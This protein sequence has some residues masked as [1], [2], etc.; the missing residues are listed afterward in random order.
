MSLTTS[1]SPHT[2]WSSVVETSTTSDFDPGERLDQEAA[3]L[4]A[5]VDL[6]ER[7]AAAPDLATACHTAAGELRQY[8]NCERVVF[9]LTGYRGSRCRLKAVSGAADFDAAAPLT[10]AIE[11]AFDEALSRD[12]LTSW[13]PAAEAERHTLAAHRKVAELSG[14]IALFTIR[15]PG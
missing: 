15:W 7:V 8:L 11:D 2:S 6:V 10:Q 3:D 12:E 5:I 14:T 4:A 13:P 9:G 1:F